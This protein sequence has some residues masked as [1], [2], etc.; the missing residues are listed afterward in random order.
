MVRQG[1]DAKAGRGK[2]R[3]RGVWY[4]K[5]AVVRRSFVSSRAVLLAAVRFG[6]CGTVRHGQVWCRV[7]WSGMDALV[8]PGM[9]WCRI[10]R[11]GSDA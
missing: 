4:G 1:S 3:C 10:V 6:C 2:V 8:W 9:V 11:C 7:V 5:D